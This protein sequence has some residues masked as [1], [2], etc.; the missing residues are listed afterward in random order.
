MDHC[1]TFTHKRWASPPSVTSNVDKLFPKK[2]N[3]RLYLEVPH[4]LSLYGRPP[5][6]PTHLLSSGENWNCQEF[7]SGNTRFAIGMFFV[8]RYGADWASGRKAHG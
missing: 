4:L 2:S 5:H 3:Q 7:L 1:P 6:F 8:Y